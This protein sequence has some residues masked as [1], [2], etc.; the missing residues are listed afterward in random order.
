[1]LLLYILFLY[2]LNLTRYYYCYFC[3]FYSQC[4]FRFTHVFTHSVLL[5]FL[6][7]FILLFV[8]HLLV[9]H[10]D[11]LS[12]FL[13]EYVF[14]LSSFLKVLLLHIEFWVGRISPLAFKNTILLSSGFLCFCGEVSHQF[15]CFFNMCLSLIAYKI[16]FLVFTNITLMT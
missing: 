8:A 3:H 11:E 12:Q 5:F 13:S 15:C 2:I 4:S 6:Y 1:M 16:Y 14:I 7:L 9:F 10:V